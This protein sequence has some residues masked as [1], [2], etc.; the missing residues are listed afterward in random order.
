MERRYSDPIR[1]R[2][3]LRNQSVSDRSLHSNV[4]VV[5]GG[6]G[7]LGSMIAEELDRRGSRLVIGGRN[8][9][10]LDSVTA[11]LS[12]AVPCRLD[13][14]DAVSVEHA[15][16]LAIERFGRLDGLVNAAG[17][18]AFGPLEELSG[19]TLRDLITVDLVGPLDLIRA[20]LPH[21]DGGF[22]VNLP[23]VVAEQP[24]GNMAAYSAAKAGLSAASVALN[25]ELRRRQITILDA[26]PPHT[27]TGLAGRAIN[28]TAPSFPE[29]LPPASVAHRIV[30][31]IVAG[32]RQL[33]A[34][35]FQSVDVP[36][37]GVSGAGSVTR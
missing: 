34:G 2:R 9:D 36:W 19:E 3:H 33:P 24:V 10:R 28:G 20:A 11:E 32:E 22:V 35:A 27:E 29:G 25:R 37:S 12:D 13:F 4:V 17:V 14:F 23:G 21:L 8:P 30:E 1:S 31:G 15:V 26:R 7:V 18:V 5:A 16:T 6:T